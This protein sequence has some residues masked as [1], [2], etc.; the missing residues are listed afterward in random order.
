M[1]RILTVLL[2]AVTPLAA[3]STT[4]G[5]TVTATG[6][7]TIYVTPDQAQFT[8]SVVTQAATAQDAAQQN[9]TMTTAVLTAIKAVLGSAGSVQTVSYS[10]SP[11]TSNAN[12]PMIVGYTAINQVQVTV[13]D[14]SL[15]GKLIDAANQSGA[16]SIGGLTFG[17]QNPEPTVLQALTAATK[18]ALTHANAIALG[19]NGGVGPV[20]SVQQSSAYAPVVVGTA[21][22]AAPTTPVQT[23]TVSVYAS[24]TLTAQLQ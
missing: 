6:S 19:I 22:G 24:V 5:R 20:L 17:L 21:A 15:I 16:N 2:F 4:A 12:P 3:Q 18:Q 9:A 11:R 13:T 14:L 8:A 10:I 7:A 23:G 1:R